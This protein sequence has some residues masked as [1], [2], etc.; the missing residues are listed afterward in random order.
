MDKVTETWITVPKR[1][2]STTN[3]QACLVHI[4][5][6]GPGMGSRCM[7]GDTAIVLGRDHDCDL[8]ITD[9]SVSRHHARIQPGIDGYYVVDLQSTNGTFVN[10]KPASMYKLKDGDYMRVGNWIFRYMTGCNDEAASYKALHRL[11]I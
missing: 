11:T 8:S 4:Y 7:L 3:R 9:Q 6:T 2:V 1:P 10:D 5:P